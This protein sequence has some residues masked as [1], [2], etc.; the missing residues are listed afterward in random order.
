MSRSKTGFSAAV[1]ALLFVFAAPVVAQQMAP[2]ASASSASTDNT[3]M[4]QRDRSSETMKPTDQPN[5]RTDIKV[6][7]AVRRAILNDKSLSTMAH[8]VKLVAAN[9]VVTL[10]GPVADADE[11]AKVEALTAAVGGVNHVDN[12]LD[13]KH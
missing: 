13:I 8:N 7:A 2:S 5:D 10:R 4:N 9:G 1:C 12:Q 11:K 3:S 6:A